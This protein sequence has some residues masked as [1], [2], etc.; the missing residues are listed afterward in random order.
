MKLT[1]YGAAEGVTGSCHLIDVGDRRVM[2]D[3]GLFQ[4][5]G[6]HEDNEPP[7]P[8]DPSSVD[9]LLVSHAHLDHIGRIPLLEREGFRGQ[10]ISTRPTLDLARLSLMDS[11]RIMDADVRRY[12]RKRDRDEPAREPLFDEDD[13]F[14]ALDRWRV[15]VPYRTPFEVCPGVRATFFDAGHILG[16]AFILLELTE[17][18]QVRRLIYSGDLGN[19]HKPIIH[20]PEP[21]PEAD[22]LLL[23][24]TYGNREHRPFVD[25]VAE[26]EEAIRDTLARGGNVLI[27]SF[28]L[29][30]AQE[31]LYVL[32]EAWIA[33][34]IP[35]EVRI[36]L[37]SPMA[38]DATKIF[39]RYPGF[40]DE[41]AIK[42]AR[43]GGNPFHFDALTYSR[44]SDDSRRINEVRSGAIIIAGSGMCTGG[45]IL[46]HLARNLERPE[47]GVIFCGYQSHGTL[48]RR[49]VD[50]AERVRIYGVDVAVR[51]Q[52][53]TINGFSGHA[54]RDTLTTWAKATHASTIL[55][56]HGE[57][58]VRADFA[59]HLRAELT[60]QPHVMVQAFDAPVD[61]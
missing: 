48:G 60:P 55:L 7:L 58:D 44:H 17:G 42:L 31:L 52:V 33:G 11:A 24:S 39:T 8:F 54:G 22:V 46:H 10:I 38:V 61:L 1:S 14:N 56:V 29:E 51:A 35:H 50:R 30:R 5:A 57:D 41:H 21:P 9:V 27:P 53:H 36:F 16:S 18:D 49:I 15:T 2:L 4:G 25:T 3:C 32:Y 20:D 45:R 40:F 23:E 47:C 37:D 13:V 43:E 19:L 59:Q 6:S 26:L 28:A 12:N 34:R